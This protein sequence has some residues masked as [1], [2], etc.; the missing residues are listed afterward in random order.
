MIGVMTISE[1]RDDSRCMSKLSKEGR[2]IV[3]KSSF[4]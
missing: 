1:C 2:L 4:Q 3:P